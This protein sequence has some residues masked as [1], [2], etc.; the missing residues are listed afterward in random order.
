MCG[1]VNY[2]EIYCKYNRKTIPEYESNKLELDTLSR[3]T[4]LEM[5]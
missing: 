2:N 5:F 4:I 1:K 3:A